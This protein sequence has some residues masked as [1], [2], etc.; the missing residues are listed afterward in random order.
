MHIL[1]SFFIVFIFIISYLF[2][3]HKIETNHVLEV[4]HAS[5]SRQF[6]FEIIPFIILFSVR[7][8]KF[9]DIST[10]SDFFNS[11]IGRSIIGMIAFTFVTFSLTST[12]P[13]NTGTNVNPAN[14]VIDPSHSMKLNSFTPYININEQ[15]D[16][17]DINAYEKH[18]KYATIS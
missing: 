4:M 8:M 13:I 11:V 9:V 15:N 16:I 2:F 3:Y 17:K 10:S 18:I 5:F 1:I 6:I 14:P 7:E 12:T